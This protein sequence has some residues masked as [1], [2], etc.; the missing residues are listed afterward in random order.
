MHLNDG[1]F[2]HA[3][4][5][6]LK[7]MNNRPSVPLFEANPHSRASD[8]KIIGS[9][10]Y[11]EEYWVENHVIQEFAS[12]LPTSHPI[13]INEMDALREAFDIIFGSS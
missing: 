2:A 6:Y 11:L 8:R 1:P 13:S 9:E 10:E 5:E 4:I 7:I 12:T 3:F